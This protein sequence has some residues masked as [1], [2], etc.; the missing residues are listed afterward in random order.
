M[1]RDG[2]LRNAKTLRHLADSCGARAQALDDATADRVGERLEGIVTHLGNNTASRKTGPISQ[3]AHAG[4]LRTVLRRPHRSCSV[5]GKHALRL[6]RL[7]RETANCALE[8]A[9]P[10]FDCGSRA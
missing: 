7:P 4:A 5:A 1:L 9:S 10:E 3:L 6:G 2:G 8:W